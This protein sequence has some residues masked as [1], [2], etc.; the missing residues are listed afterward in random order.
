MRTETRKPDGTTAVV[1][2]LVD[3]AGPLDQVV[4]KTT[5][6]GGA[7]AAL[8]AY[9]VRGDVPPPED[10]DINPRYRSFDA[11]VGK[12]APTGRTCPVRGSTQY[13]SLCVQKSNVH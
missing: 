3:S 8:S 2:Y 11:L 6:V 7:P 10:R 13:P 1:D 12:A 4:A 5:S 9:Y